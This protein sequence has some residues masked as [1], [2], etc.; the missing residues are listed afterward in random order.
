[1]KKLP[2]LFFLMCLSCSQ[3]RQQNSLVRLSLTQNNTTLQFSGLDKLVL[4]D[5]ARDSNNAVWQSL[6]PVYKMPADTDMKNYQPEQPGKYV[7][8]DSIVAFTPDTPFV[9]GK[10][11]FVRNYKP[12]QASTNAD[13]IKGRGKA[14]KM[15]YI[16]LIFKP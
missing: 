4:N 11:Y 8:K 13:Y 1:M 10:T 3:P 14:G 2:Y 9:K 5:I 15:H 6:I 16:D 12:G 7:I